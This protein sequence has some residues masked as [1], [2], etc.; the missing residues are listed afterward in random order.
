MAQT[1]Q[2]YAGNFYNTYKQKHSNSHYEF[3]LATA[4][5]W[6]IRTYNTKQLDMF[7][8]FR[9]MCLGFLQCDS[10]A[11]NKNQSIVRVGCAWA[12]ACVCLCTRI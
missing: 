3:T 4:I 7:S 1:N 9:S 10:D 6:N 11:F 8:R 2:L 12:R 5:S